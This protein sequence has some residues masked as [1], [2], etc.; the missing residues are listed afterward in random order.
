MRAKIRYLV[1]WGTLTSLL[2]ISVPV[3]A[4]KTTSDIQMLQNLNSLRAQK[5]LIPLVACKFLTKSAQ[6]YAANM[7][8]NNFFGHVGKDGSSPGDRIQSAGYN[9]KNP[10]TKSMVAENIAAGQTTVS[11]VMDSWK[12]SPG[13]Y[14]NM[15]ERVFTHVGFGMAINPSSKFKIY[16]VQNFGYGAPC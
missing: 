12:N 16:W 5:G 11:Q 6:S 15:V 14:R 4:S 13:H 10:L 8:K 1:F 7:A 3:S 9:W 2:C